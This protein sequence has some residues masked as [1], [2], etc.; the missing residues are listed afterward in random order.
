MKLQVLLGLVAAGSSLAQP[1]STKPD[2]AFPPISSSGESPEFVLSDDRLYLM[3]SGDIGYSV[4]NIMWFNAQTGEFDASR[5]ANLESIGGNVVIPDGSGGWLVGGGFSQVNGLVRAGI[6]RFASD[7][8][9]SDWTANT[10]NH[11]NTGNILTL[12]RNGDSLYIGGLFTKVG[13]T[14]P[15]SNLAAISL[16]KPDHPLWIPSISGGDVSNLVIDNGRLFVAGSF[17]DINAVE[18]DG[19]AVFDLS[20][21]SPILGTHALMG[22][23]GPAIQAVAVNNNI[24]YL[25]GTFRLNT[26]AQSIDV[27]HGIA[28]INLSNGS[29]SGFLVE[30]DST[31]D[32]LAFADGTLFAGGGF[33]QIDGSLRS[34]FASF[35]TTTG[36]LQPTS[37]SISRL[38]GTAQVLAMQIQQDQ[39]L[40]GGKFTHVNSTE[41]V[42]FCAI[43]RVTYELQPVNAHMQLSNGNGVKAFSSD[44]QTTVV[45]GGV[46]LANAEHRAPFVAIDLETKSVLPWAPLGAA[47]F[48][49]VQAHLIEPWQD[50]VFLAVQPPS[51]APYTI[52][53]HTFSTRLFA[54]SADTGELMNEFY[55]E[56]QSPR[57]MLSTNDALY[58]YDPGPGGGLVC[59]DPWTGKDRWIREVNIESM[60]VLGETYLHLN[61]GTT[62]N[63]LLQLT[64]GRLVEA[65]LL[66]EPMIQDVAMIGST[67]W[68]SGPQSWNGSPTKRLVGVRPVGFDAAFGQPI[69]PNI[70]LSN[71]PQIDIAGDTLIVAQSQLNIPNQGYNSY[72][73]MFNGHTGELLPWQI[74]SSFII[75]NFEVRENVGMVV[76]HNGTLEGVVRYDTFAFFPWTTK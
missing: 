11:N 58:V 10:F 32:T 33:Q 47:T 19:F 59:L 34:G 14:E 36:M 56:A 67:L 44:G 24:A 37:I 71:V 49:N 8:S 26:G 27:L 76:R 28:G 54:V 64:T 39:L 48:G 52:N 25:S 23:P 21:H 3:T 60:R 35:D 22:S 16:S 1:I 38:G 7:G 41:R 74:D 4:N 42:G 15:V 18:Y 55:H 2:T 75:D 45:T 53:G 57:F 46:Q 61:S 43:N 29:W 9:L 5:I 51:A 70:N 13:D 65:P 62:P 6:T 20:T 40:I 31:I 30:A 50:R 69:A 63:G 72:I 73:A 17:S 68:I 12:A 66:A